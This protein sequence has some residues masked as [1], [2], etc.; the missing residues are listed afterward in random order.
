VAEAAELPRLRID[1]RPKVPPYGF[2]TTVRV[3]GW[4]VGSD[5]PG[6]DEA[7]ADALLSSPFGEA[8]DTSVPFFQLVAARGALLVRRNG[9]VRSPEE[10]D[11]H[12]RALA[13]AAGGLRAAASAVAR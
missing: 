7:A 2:A 8:L 1:R 5:A 4:H 11:R 13:T 12:A 9:F 6:F 10:L 3:H